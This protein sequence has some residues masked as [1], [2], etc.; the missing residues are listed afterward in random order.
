MNVILASASPRRRQLLEQVG[1]CF[2]VQA[3]DVMEA[4]KPGLSPAELA[5]SLAVD[6]ATSVAATADSQAV[7]IGADTIVVYKGEVFGKPNNQ[8]QA[9][10][11]L[12]SLA[13]QQHQV[14]T[15]VTVVADGEVFSDCAVTLVTFRDLTEAEIDSYIETDEW[16][17]KAGS[18]GIQ[19]MG[20]LLVERI[21]GCYANVVG[22]PLVTL[23]RLLLRVGVRLL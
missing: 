4:A 22:L 17:D 11:M 16:V 8:E 21:E 5:K 23:S 3:S 7:V 12:H 18:Y 6:K 10:D 15:G 13:G 19:G 2:A 20:A 1:L 14:I 9:R